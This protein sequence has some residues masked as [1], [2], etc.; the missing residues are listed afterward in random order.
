ML[1]ECCLMRFD[2]AHD[3]Y[4]DCQ[5]KDKRNLL[6]KCLLLLMHVLEEVQL[7]SMGPCISYKVKLEL[8]KCTC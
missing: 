2:Q 4:M 7:H 1:K 5:V 6:M 3:R 8:E